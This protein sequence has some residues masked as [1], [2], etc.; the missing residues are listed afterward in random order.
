MRRKLFNVAAA[1]SLLAGVAT[2]MLWARSFYR[3]DS[4]KHLS[5]DAGKARARM[6]GAWSERGGIALFL[7]DDPLRPSWYPGAPGFSYETGPS[8]RYAF[9][10]RTGGK[11]RRA[12]GFMFRSETDGDPTLVVPCWSVVLACA[13]LP[14][15]W[16]LNHSRRRRRRGC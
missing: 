16:L 12:L 2:A 14:S 5:I 3:V 6:I 9:S 7:Q 10:G 15:L 11:Q 8:S 4:I 13:L 1:L